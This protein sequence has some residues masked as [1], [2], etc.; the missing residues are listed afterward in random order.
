MQM[1]HSAAF[2]FILFL[3]NIVQYFSLRQ[4]SADFF[5]FFFTKSSPI[6]FLLRDRLFC[7]A[8][9]EQLGDDSSFCLE[10]SALRR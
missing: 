1:V 5:F 10:F 2:Y 6:F 8:L 9:V 3:L 7:M 4:A